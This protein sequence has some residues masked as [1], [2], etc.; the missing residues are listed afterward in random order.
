MP[1]A[2]PLAPFRA[3]LEQSADE[4]ERA[5]L[6][7]LIEDILR[8]ALGSDEDARERL[9]ATIRDVVRKEFGQGTAR[10]AAALRRALRDLDR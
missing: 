6:A 3:M 4:A 5:R 2:D 10:I 7:L 9:R 8:E 1:A